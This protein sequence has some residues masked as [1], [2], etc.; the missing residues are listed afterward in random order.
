MVTLDLQSQFSCR[1][2]VPIIMAGTAIPAT[3][4]IPTGAPIN[5][6][7]CHNNFFFRDQG[8][9]P[10]KVQPDGL[11]DSNAFIKLQPLEIRFDRKLTS[12]N[13]NH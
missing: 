11:Q 3:N 10:Q 1:V 6:P 12:D 13:V 8:F 9:L 2:I 4:A 7:S 5:V